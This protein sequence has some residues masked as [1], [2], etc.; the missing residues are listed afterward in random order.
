[1]LPAGVTWCDEVDQPGC[2]DVT[3]GLTPNPVPKLEAYLAD[4]SGSH[5][6]PVIARVLGSDL[7]GAQARFSSGSSG[8]PLGGGFG[9]GEWMVE[10]D[11]HRPTAPRS[12][13]RPPRSSLRSPTA[14]PR[15]QFAIVLDKVVQSAPSI[16]EDVAG[17]RDRRGTR[18][19]HPGDVRRS[20]EAANDLAVVLKYGALPVAFT[21]SSVESMSATLGSDSLRAG[22][23]AGIAGLALVA[24]AMVLYYRALGLIN[25]IGLPVFGS[26][27]LGDL[28]RCSGRGRG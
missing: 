15:R 22:L 16:A 18:R 7:Q 9:G 27:M 26:A 5:L 25:V 17:D 11:L 24:V 10:L 3:T 4:D 23:I 14:T 12:S 8:S 13:P 28:L 20:G 6:S 19:D 21:Q 1:M 2:V